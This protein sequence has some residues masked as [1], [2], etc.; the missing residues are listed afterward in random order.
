MNLQP[1]IN[2][3]E[4]KPNYMPMKRISL[5]LILL[6][7][8]QLRSQ[9]P[10]VPIG[11]YMADPSGHQWKDGKLYV[12]GSRDES[13]A[14]YCSYDY[15]VLSTSDLKNWMVHKDVFSSKG[16][17]DQ[18]GY[19]DELL[20]APDCIYKNGTYYMYY[21]MGGVHNV[22][23]VATSK[24]PKGPFTKGSI[25][26]H[27]QQI[28]PA[29]FIDDDGQAYYLWGQFTGKIAKLNPDMKSI[30]P[31]SIKENI[32]TEAEHH[33]HEGI[34]MFKRNGI[35]YLAYAHIGRRGMATCIGYST[36]D[37]PMGP[38]TYGG[39]I[40]D[41]FGSDPYVWNNHGSVV[42]FNDDWYI[43]YH[44][45]TAGSERMRKACMEP[46]EFNED[47]SINEVEMTT[48]GVAG[49]LDPFKKMDAERS[50][51]LT[52]DVR[53]TKCAADNEELSSIRDQNTAAYKYF[54]FRKSP[55]KFTVS[56]KSQ[57]GG[58]LLVYANNLSLPLLATVE[59]P[60]GDGDRE[61]IFS[62]PIDTQLTG[63]APIYFRF[64]GERGQDLFKVDWFVFE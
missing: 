14:Y 9:N 42:K 31:A 49:P 62:V 29:V 12:Y 35:Y 64:A 30:D 61:T 34:Q 58:K 8:Y 54:D 38:Y 18:V 11:S 43:M 25:I 47:G 16:K 21:C 5:L 45:S 23:G 33:F 51:Y 32:I 7:P 39:V 37:N 59:V 17:N 44:R 26:E 63:I 56:I 15:D 10:I 46:I 28:D 60:A 19:S 4:S 24:S 55:R 6:I 57:A 1:D 40:I 3:E 20:F 48:Q 13:T 50:C 27:A 52:G 53:I 22:E 36:A 2:N 41:N